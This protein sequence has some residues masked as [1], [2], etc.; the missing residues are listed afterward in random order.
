MIK[1]AATWFIIGLAFYVGSCW[2]CYSIGF[3]LGE[4]SGIRWSTKQVFGTEK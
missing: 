3:N 4:A 1:E 2:Y